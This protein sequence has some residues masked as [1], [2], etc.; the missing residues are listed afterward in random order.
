MLTATSLLHGGGR[1]TDLIPWAN[2]CVCCAQRS[3]AQIV[4]GTR[5]RRSLP[6]SHKRPA[7]G[8]DCN[9]CTAAD[10]CSPPR[11][12]G[13]ILPV[14]PVHLYSWWH[15]PSCILPI[16]AAARRPKCHHTYHSPGP[17]GHRGCVGLSFCHGFLTPT[18]CLCLPYTCLPVRVYVIVAGGTA[19]VQKH[20]PRLRSPNNLGNNTH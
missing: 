18:L 2:S 16:S 1:R 11:S 5:T 8:Q 6:P 20:L 17:F 7:H 13:L 4:S 14:G 12:R 9:T 3:V 10:T 15:C 19:G